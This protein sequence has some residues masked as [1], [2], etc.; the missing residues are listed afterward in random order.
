MKKS[1]YLILILVFAALLIPA[2]VYAAGTFYCSTLIAEGGNGSYAYPWAC[3]T[4]AQFN[5][6]VYDVICGQYGGGNLYRIYASSYV[7]YQIE[8]QTVENQ[9]VCTIVYQA[10][11][12]GYPPDTG[13]ELPMPLIIGAAV[14]AGGALLLVG[15][16]LRR[17][18]KTT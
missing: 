17:K 4:D 12:P 2:T 15:L 3:S 7:F 16:V 9:A 18:N 10:E 13:V 1:R 14:A 6:I 8:W 11:Y 5:H